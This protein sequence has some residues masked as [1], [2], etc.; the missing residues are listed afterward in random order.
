M[1][2]SPDPLLFKLKTTNKFKQ[3]FSLHK[4]ILENMGNH[5]LLTPLLP[6]VHDITDCSLSLYNLSPFQFSTPKG[7]SNSKEYQHAFSLFSDAKKYKTLPLYN[8]FQYIYFSPY[9]YIHIYIFYHNRH[10][11][12][13][14][15]LF[16]FP[17]VNRIHVVHKNKIFTYSLKKIIK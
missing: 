12:N 1:C 11:I 4:A 10:L 9:I 14:T 13:R 8:F 15:L 5:T 6:E 7:D 16:L 3:C 2:T 17:L